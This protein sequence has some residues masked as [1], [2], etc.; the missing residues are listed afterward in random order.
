MGL[1]SGPSCSVVVPVRDGEAT[2]DRCLRAIAA[3]GGEAIELIVV[4]DGSIDAS[5]AIAAKYTTRVLRCEGN[6]PAT[7]RNRGAA[8]ATRPI[9]IFV[10]ADCE[11]HDDAIA[12]LA[13]F[14]EQNPGYVAAFG[15]YDD[16]PPYR[17]TVSLFKNLSHHHVHQGSRE[18]A[19]TF[20]SGCGA[21]RRDAF[22]AA[23][24]FDER[25]ARPQIEDIELGYRLTG[26]GGRI[27]L[28]K[29][30]QAKHLKAW[31]FRSM[32]SSDL[33]DRAI[34]WSR[35]LIARGTHD[36]LNLSRGDRLAAVTAWSS[37]ACIAASFVAPVA[38][39][40]LALLLPLLLF[41]NR[42]LYRLF[43]KLGARFLIAAF[44]LHVLQYLYSS[45]AFGLV[46]LAS[47]VVPGTNSRD[48]SRI[49]AT[50]AVLT[51]L[52]LALLVAI[53][54]G[55]AEDTARYARWAD[56]L[57]LDLLLDEPRRVFFLLF[58]LL[59]K[60]MRL[61]LGDSW[62]LGIAV[63]NAAAYGVSGALLAHAAFRITS[64]PAAFLIAAAL[65]AS[66]F[67][68]VNWSRFAIADSMLLL[69]VC[70]LVERM[71]ARAPLPAQLLLVALA[72]VTRPTGILL[73]VPV[74]A[75]H[76]YDRRGG[77]PD[78]SAKRLALTVGAM[79]S[80][81]AAWVSAL[82]LMIASGASLPAPLPAAVAI[83]ARGEVVQG[84][85][86]T[87]HASPSS[88][89]ECMLLWLDKVIRFWQPASGDFSAAHRAADLVF[90]VP[91]LAGAAAAFLLLARK[92]LDAPAARM[93]SAATVAIT[94]FTLFHSLH[95][96][97]F[98]WRYRLP[99]LPFV[100]LMAVTALAASM[101]AD[102]VPSERS[103]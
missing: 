65:Y 42:D 53:G 95:Q 49:V 86:D 89:A 11:L 78:S 80:A 25:Y 21:V 40:G 8:A 44:A 57:S 7:A 103:R 59:A 39:A 68:L 22:L 56:D 6:G 99:A 28:L 18:E 48:R 12:I 72:S 37:V 35:L 91:A 98:D 15:S 26:A 101:P 52:A 36:D 32:V 88:W 85:W 102:A 58:V 69:F 75:L 13:G 76:R 63:L 45:A 1:S 33:F 20:W 100:I 47:L 38:L 82:P 96:I 55:D 50:A 51:A 46:S 30:A 2:L 41:I 79:F 66:S 73:L 16:A 74:V 87:Y 62:H 10:D 83:F 61:V 24:G 54:P 17:G 43:A 64:R 84:R 93:V 60:A 71:S 3:A 92:R 81:A 94:T 97:D 14:L 5:A 77:S 9:V 31:T 67:E 27:R 4:D 90:Y 23:G 29:R 19:T 34:P 70:L